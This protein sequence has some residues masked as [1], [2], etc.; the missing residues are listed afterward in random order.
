[1]VWSA[2]SGFPGDL[3]GTRGDSYK[4]T[5]LTITS[6]TF[7]VW[8]AGSGFPGDLNGTQG[9]RLRSW[10]SRSGQPS[11]SGAE[12]WPGTALTPAYI[13]FGVPAALLALQGDTGKPTQT[14]TSHLLNR[15]M[16]K[17]LSGSM[18]GLSGCLPLVALAMLMAPTPC[19][20]Y[21]CQAGRG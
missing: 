2:G 8:S 19:F 20:L 17:H 21:M 15:L 3:N 10:T 14:A 1:M 7:M 6:R 5:V 16:V 18:R 12:T 11:W 4:Q 13:V 9:W